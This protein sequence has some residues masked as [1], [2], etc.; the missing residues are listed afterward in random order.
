MR[1]PS[2]QMK[3]RRFFMKQI[4]P[5]K[6]LKFFPIIPKDFNDQGISYSKEIYSGRGRG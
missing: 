5:P 2:V 1:E 3:D 4:T 6:G